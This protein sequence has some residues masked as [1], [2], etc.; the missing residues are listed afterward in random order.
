[1][2]LSHGKAYVALA[3]LQQL[4]LQTCHIAAGLGLYVSDTEGRQMLSE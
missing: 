2:V 4:P 3:Q 1:M